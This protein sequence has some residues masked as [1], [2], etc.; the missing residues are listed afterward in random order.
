M[1]YLVPDTNVYF[2]LQIVYLILLEFRLSILPGYLFI[3]HMFWFVIG[4]I[5]SYSFDHKLLLL[6]E[7]Q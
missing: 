1:H 7:Y 2:I 5:K 6:S 4:E 3:F